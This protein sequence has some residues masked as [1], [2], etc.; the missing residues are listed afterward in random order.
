MRRLFILLMLAVAPAVQ[1]GDF[2]AYGGIEIEPVGPSTQDE[3]VIVVG[4]PICEMSLESHELVVSGGVIQ[5]FVE[6]I[7]GACGV[8][9]P[10]T[11]RYEMPLGLLPAGDYRVDYFVSLQGGP[12]ELINTAD[13]S[14]VRLSV[15]I[16]TLGTA[17][18]G[19][20]ALLLC[21]AAASTLRRR[22]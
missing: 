15:E 10:A 7:G 1:A 17:G 2:I 18:A 19:L 6:A 8:P 12:D 4:K 11:D 21:G 9:P 16:P 3:I 14:V 13:F 5:A 20:L 22:R